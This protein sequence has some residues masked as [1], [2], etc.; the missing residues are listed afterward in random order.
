M[1]KIIA[2]NK[3][4]RFDYEILDTYEAGVALTGSETKS[5]RN[6]GISLKDSFVS[7]IRDEM[8]WQNGHIAV[9]EMSSYNNHAPDRNRKLLLNRS[10]IEKINR[11]M[12]E[13][14]LS[15]IPLSVYWKAGRVKIKIALGKGKKR[16]DK[17]DAIKKKDVDARLRQSVRRRN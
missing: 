14:G 8:F 9:Y 16:H 4:G 1:G 13:K 12:R 7:L 10:E 6:G 2:Q 15:C 5:I 3:K 17:R 11:A